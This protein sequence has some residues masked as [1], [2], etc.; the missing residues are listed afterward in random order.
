MRGSKA[1]KA[2]CKKRLS[3]GENECMLKA[4]LFGEKACKDFVNPIENNIFASDKREGSRKNRFLF[5]S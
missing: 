2:T 4:P 5:C 1:V 3:L